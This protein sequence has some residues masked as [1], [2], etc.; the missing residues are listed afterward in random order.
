MDHIPV[1][2]LCDTQSAISE[3]FLPKL[4]FFICIIMTDMSYKK[5]ERM[6]KF[7]L[8]LYMGKRYTN[9][10]LVTGVSVDIFRSVM[11]TYTAHLIS[12]L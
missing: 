9:N 2:A 7:I 12:N 6:K 3:L 11:H 5:R 4:P 8:S 10:H 1:T